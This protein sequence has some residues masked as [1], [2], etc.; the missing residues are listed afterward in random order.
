M[1][2][3]VC[4]CHKCHEHHH[5]GYEKIQNLE[6]EIECLKDIKKKNQE[7]LKKINHLES[8]CLALEEAR[9]LINPQIP[10]DKTLEYFSRMNEDELRSKCMSLYDTFI[11][12]RGCQNE[13]VDLKEEL[14]YI[15]NNIPSE[16]WQRPEWFDYPEEDEKG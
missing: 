16:K 11:A 15:K 12:L 3:L 2:D 13:I 1:N 4:L 5:K 8:R 6:N 14:H 7:Y 10:S 9:P